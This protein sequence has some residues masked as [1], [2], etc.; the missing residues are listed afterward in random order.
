[1]PPLTAGSISPGNLL[2][3]RVANIDM[4]TFDGLSGIT[5]SLGIRPSVSLIPGIKV[6]SGDGSSSAPFEVGGE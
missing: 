6:I 2:I 1:M 5:S 4:F 3:Y